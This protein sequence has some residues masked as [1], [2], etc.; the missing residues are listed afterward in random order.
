MSDLLDVIVLGIIEGVTEFLPVSSTGHLLIVEN[1]GWVSRQSDVFNTVIQSGAV[2]AVLA[3]FA[4]RVKQ[5]ILNWKSPETTDYL[6]KLG[7]SFFITGLGGVVLKKAGLRLPAEVAPVALATLIGGILILLIEHFLKGKS[8]GNEI[9]WGVAIG[10]GIAQLVA[11]AF[12]GTSRSGATILLALAMGISR[13][14][15]TEFSFLLGIPTLFAAGGLELWQARHQLAA[16]NLFYLLIGTA[17]STITA[18]LVV[19]WLL[20]YVQTHTFI[21]FGWY[22]IA[23]GFLLFII[24]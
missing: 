10:V 5:L 21:P 12:P 22:R 1:L 18:F 3:V 16:G 24:K 19:K 14:I 6:I 23:L 17:V 15:A 13:P 9:T 8:L 4:R 20:K 11:G 2:L 7:V